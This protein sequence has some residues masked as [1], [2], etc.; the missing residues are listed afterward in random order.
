MVDGAIRHG[1][2]MQ[3]VA[4]YVDTHGQSE[5]GFGITKLLG[6]DLLPRIKRINKVKLYRPA[7]GEQDAWPGLAPALTRPIRW[8]RVTEQYDQMVKYA[9][10]IR[11]GTAS[12]EAIL[13][14][15]MKANAAH[16]TYQAMIEL[17]R[18]QKT[19][20][21][22]RYLRSPAPQREI[23][24]GLNA[25]ESWN[26]AN[27]VIFYGKG[28]DL[29]GNHR[30]EQEMSVLCLRILQAALVYVNTLM[31][32]DL[33]AEPD[34]DD[35]PDT[36]GPARPDPTVLVTRPALRRGEAEH[37]QQAPAQHELTGR[38]SW[39]WVAV[40]RIWPCGHRQLSRHERRS[41]GPLRSRRAGGRWRRQPRAA[42]DARPT[43]GVAQRAVGLVNGFVNDGIQRWVN[44]RSARRRQERAHQ[45][46]WRRQRSRRSRCPPAA[47]RSP[48]WPP[49]DRSGVSGASPPRVVRPGPCRGVS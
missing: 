21:L 20:F 13:R 6:F 27:T 30:D 40:V 14:R 23:H 37:D 47:S 16:P 48:R 1:T 15:F 12:T 17:G 33:L 41:V 18:A 46:R 2:E 25:V 4:N 38:L 22:A 7:T 34:W 42:F 32:Q 24:E 36:R 10:A 43:R 11:T 29:A 35:V 19:I 8:D 5:I 28:S 26:R 44:V 39:G 45:R 3:V 31:L 49:T 9:T